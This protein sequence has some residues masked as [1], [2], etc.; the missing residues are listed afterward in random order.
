MSCTIHLPRLVVQIR[1]RTGWAKINGATLH[2][3]EYLENHQR[4]NQVI[5]CTHEGQCILNTSINRWFNNVILYSGAIWRKLSNN[6]QHCSITA[7]QIYTAQ[8]KMQN[9][10]N[11]KAQASLISSQTC[12]TNMLYVSSIT[13]SYVF[14]AVLPLTDTSVKKRNCDNCCHAVTVSLFSSHRDLKLQQ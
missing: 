12:L 6:N 13:L 5:F 3:P 14:K 2:F 8:V 1:T 7:S 11:S 4:Y 10:S 9:D